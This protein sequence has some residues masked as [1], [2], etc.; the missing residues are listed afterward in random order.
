MLR[1]EFEHDICG[2]MARALTTG[3]YVHLLLF[4]SSK[5]FVICFYDFSILF[6][7]LFY[8]LSDSMF[9]VFITSIHFKAKVIGVSTIVV[10]NFNLNINKIFLG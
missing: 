1:P 5:G 9:S 8:D 7:S 10:L 3:T 2:S 4:A 6:Y